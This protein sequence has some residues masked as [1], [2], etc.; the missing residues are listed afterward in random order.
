MQAPMQPY[1]V[2]EAYSIPAPRHRRELPRLARVIV[3]ALQA[4]VV[5]AGFAA[6]LI[7][8]DMLGRAL[9]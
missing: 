6:V 4:G 3:A 2:G 5:M 1:P 9:Y 8:A 7:F